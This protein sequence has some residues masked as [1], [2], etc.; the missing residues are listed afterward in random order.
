METYEWLK[1][2]EVNENQD[3]WR[4]FWVNWND[5]PPNAQYSEEIYAKLWKLNV[6]MW[7]TRSDF[8]PVK[9]A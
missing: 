3:L 1:W 9:T 6:A 4:E 7:W 8:K 2:P 5:F